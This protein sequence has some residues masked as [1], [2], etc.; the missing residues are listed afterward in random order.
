[1]GRQERIREQLLEARRCRELGVTEVRRLLWSLPG[2][3][4]RRERA[5][6]QLTPEY[7][8]CEED[9]RAV[10]D[11]LAMKEVQLISMDCQWSEDVV[12]M[13]TET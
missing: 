8:F 3:S 11:V 5:R 9:M 1:M 13:M 2:H 4:G 7:D 6:L 12:G 10:L